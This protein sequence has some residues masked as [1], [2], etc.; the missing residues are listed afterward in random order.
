M[1]LG[2]LP[3]HSI[4]SVSSSC[5]ELQ[6]LGND[7]TLWQH[8]VLRDFGKSQAEV[9]VFLKYCKFTVSAFATCTHGFLLLSIESW[10]LTPN[11]DPIYL[12]AIIWPPGIDSCI[13][14]LSIYP[15]ILIR[16]WPL[17]TDPWVLSPVWQ[18]RSHKMGWIILTILESW[19]YMYV[20]QRMKSGDEVKSSLWMSIHPRV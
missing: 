15:W 17:N 10:L 14:I 13:V 11:I 16:R 20:Q 3:V 2:R 4:L 5:R 1:V 18:G 8:L 7:S 9:W 12:W 6:S 19:P